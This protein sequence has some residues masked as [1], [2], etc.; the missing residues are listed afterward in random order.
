[1]KHLRDRRGRGAMDRRAVLV[2]A[3]ATAAAGAAVLP[4]LRDRQ[5]KVPVFLAR[6]QRYDGSVERTIR[7]GLLA[8]GL[9]PEGLR[10]KR[11]LLKPNM[12]EPSRLAPHMTTHPA[13]LLAAAEVFRGWGARVVVGEAPGHVRDTELALEESG[14]GEALAA[15]KLEFADLNYDEVVWVKNQSRVSPLAGLYL[16]RSVA[17]AD[18]VVSLPKLKTHHWVGVTLSLKNM[19]GTLPGIMY[20][21]PKNVLHHAGIPETVIDINAA[22]PPT[23]AVIDGIVGMEG[24][25]PIMGTPKPMGIIAVGTNLT[26]LDATCTRVMGF[27]PQAVRYLELARGRLGPIE[28]EQIVQRGERWQAV[29]AVFQI[30]DREHLRPL[31]TPEPGVLTS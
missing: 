17:E 27:N 16:P 30:L 23:V 10:G 7:D 12:V 3:C 4:W 31:R 5:G 8:T 21:W 19:Y 22:L 6:H 13:V 24:D 28:D 18:L 11:V 15:A 26:A 14:L 1:M 20:G 9:E 29:R 25:G 2:G